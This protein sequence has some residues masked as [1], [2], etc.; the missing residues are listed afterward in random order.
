VLVF[1]AMAARRSAD[2]AMLVAARHVEN[3]AYRMPW[4]QDRLGD[5]FAALDGRKSHTAGDGVVRG[6][7]GGEPGSIVDRQAERRLSILGDLEELDELAKAITSL[8]QSGAAICDRL[9][10]SM[11]RRICAADGHA[12]ADVTWTRGRTLADGNGWANP[13]CH[14]DAGPN[15]LCPG[16]DRRRRRYAE[17]HE[18]ELLAAESA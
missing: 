4:A 15:G 2:R 7:G 13:E 14:E 3:L 5:L 6:G 16:C 11:G 18:L 8:A 12:D 17:H 1:A 10:G 9:L